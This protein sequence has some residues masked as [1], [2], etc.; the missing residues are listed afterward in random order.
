MFV[1]TQSNVFGRSDKGEIT[2]NY[3]KLGVKS[4]RNWEG[5]WTQVFSCHQ[6]FAPLKK[7]KFESI[8]NIL[9]S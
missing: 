2:N 3:S 4:Q 7:M 6:F 1:E 9:Q 8:D 5:F